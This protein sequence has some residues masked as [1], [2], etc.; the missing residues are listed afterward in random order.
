MLTCF[1]FIYCHPC[2]LANFSSIRECASE[3]KEK[4]KC[5]DGLLNNAGVMYAPKSVSQDG[6]EI[7]WAVNH[8]GHYLLTK[9]LKDQLIGGRILYMINMDYR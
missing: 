1:R 3:I 7:H 9:L 4:E 6:I 8:L 5:I 2:D